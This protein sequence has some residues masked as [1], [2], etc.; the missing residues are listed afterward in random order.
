M[1]IYK[2]LSKQ[3]W[4]ESQTLGFLKPNI[5][6]N[7]FIHMCEAQQIER[8]L[9][10]FWTDLTEVVIA[11][12]DPTKLIGNLVKEKNNGGTEEYW[13]LYD[14]KI[15]LQAITEILPIESY[16]KNLASGQRLN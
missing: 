9:S 10:K 4:N 13:H 12:L 11:V 1:N 3:D 6:D 16:R 2:I 14:G 15:P 5:I 7:N 8:V